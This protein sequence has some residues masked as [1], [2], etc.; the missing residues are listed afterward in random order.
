MRKM[1]PDY[2]PSN[3]ERLNDTSTTRIIFTIHSNSRPA[4]AFV[5][6]LGVLCVVLSEKCTRPIIRIKFNCVKTFLSVDAHKYVIGL[7][8]PLCADIEKHLWSVHVNNSISKSGRR[9][10]FTH[11]IY[12]FCIGLRRELFFIIGITH[13]TQR[14]GLTTLHMPL[15]ILKQKV[16]CNK[17][18]CVQQTFIK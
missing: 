17:R 2:T 4:N 6:V 3:G 15:I 8:C 14:K 10:L 12:S 9:R 5:K 13:F 7:P 16:M 1:L 18:V 11:P